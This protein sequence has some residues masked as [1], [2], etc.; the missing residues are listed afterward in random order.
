MIFS[1]T[2][3]GKLF[4]LTFSRCLSFLTLRGTERSG[5]ERGRFNLLAW[6]FE[7]SDRSFGNIFGSLVISNLLA[8]SFEISDLVFG[9]IFATVF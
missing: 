6:S 8:W 7:I 4:S 5:A 3:L 2:L 9:N 1:G